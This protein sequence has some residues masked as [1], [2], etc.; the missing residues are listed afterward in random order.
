M[1]QQPKLVLEVFKEDQD[2]VFENLKMIN[3]IFHTFMSLDVF[4]FT[5]FFI[6]VCILSVLYIHKYMLYAL[7]IYKLYSLS[8]IIV[9]ISQSFHLK[10]IYL[11]RDQIFGKIHENSTKDGNLIEILLTHLFSF[12]AYVGK[13]PYFKVSAT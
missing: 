9:D 8:P 5:Q 7:Y 6:D 12:Q 13:D 4:F 2:V 11:H 3:F 1:K 10:P